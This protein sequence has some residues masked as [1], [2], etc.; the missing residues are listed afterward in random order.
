[1]D[2][3]QAGAFGLVIGHEVEI[4]AVSA[5]MFDGEMDILRFE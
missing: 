2:D 5:V 1:M 3:I 4:I